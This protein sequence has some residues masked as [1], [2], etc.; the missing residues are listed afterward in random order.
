MQH[1]AAKNNLS[2]TAFVRPV[3]QSYELRWF[4]PKFEI[5]LCG[6]ATLSAAFAIANFTDCASSVLRFETRSGNLSVACAGGT[7][8]MTFPARKPSACRLSEEQIRCL[9]CCPTQVWESRDLIVMLD[10]PEQVWDYAPDYGK[11]ARL[12]RWL[13][14]VLTALSIEDTDFVS[15]YFCPELNLEDPV[16]GSSH[17]SL[18]PLWAE[19]LS[20]NRLIA[21]QLSRRGASWIA[22]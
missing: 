2:K 10:T 3:G 17:G 6:H 9:G 15:R 8:R 18:T 4:T 14:I 16:M 20:K 5:D 11:L 12:D 22:A 21:R 19:K 13:G 7:Y 1:I